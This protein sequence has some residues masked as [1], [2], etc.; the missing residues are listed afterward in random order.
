MLKFLTWLEFRKEK[1]PSSK[2]DFNLPNQLFPPFFLALD[3]IIAER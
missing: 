1:F 2:N 3:A